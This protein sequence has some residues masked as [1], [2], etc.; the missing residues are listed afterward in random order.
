MMNAHRVSSA[1]LVAFSLS[2]LLALAGV[3]CAGSGSGGRGWQN[4]RPQLY[5]N[6]H[7]QQVGAETAQYDVSDCMAR[8][9]VGAPQRNTAKDGAINTVGGAAGGAALGAIGGAIAGNAGTGAAAGA[10]VGAAAGLGKTAY[11][12]RKP[13]EGFQGYVEACLR[14]KGYE[15]ISWQ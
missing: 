14:E 13:A 11:D 4:K 6:A 5:P 10:A 2:G 7:Y 1:R 3:G 15:V 12:S 9:D 8:A